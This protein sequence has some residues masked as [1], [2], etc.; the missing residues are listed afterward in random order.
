MTAGRC[1]RISPPTDGSKSTH[2][3]HRGSSS[4]VHYRRF[5]PIQGC[6]FTL[7]VLRHEMV[8]VFQI[9]SNHVRPHQPFDELADLTATDDAK[10]PLVHLLVE[11]N[12]EPLPHG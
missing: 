1:L 10:Q 12:R 11:S 8:G 9:G 2:H 4:R 6:S 3:T 5:D 7:F